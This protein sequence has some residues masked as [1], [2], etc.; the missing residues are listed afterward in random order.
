MN[1]VICNLPQGPS[2]T[3]GPPGL[4][5][6]LSRRQYSKII[7]TGVEAPINGP[8]VPGTPYYATTRVPGVQPAGQRRS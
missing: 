4:A 7:D 8:F 6:A 3:Q 1:C 2:P 5:K